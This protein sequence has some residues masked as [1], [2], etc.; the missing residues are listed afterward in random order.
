MKLYSNTKFFLPLKF[1]VRCVSHKV[2]DTRYFERLKLH[3]THSPNE[4]GSSPNFRKMDTK[5]VI[6]ISTGI[7]IHDIFHNY[8]PTKLLKV[9]MVFQQ[10]NGYWKHSACQPKNGEQILKS[11]FLFLFFHLHSEIILTNKKKMHYPYTKC[12][13]L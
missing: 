12:V 11:L 1:P 4:A 2:V 10:T 3:L 13:L 8:K 9:H 5:N 7:V 6:W